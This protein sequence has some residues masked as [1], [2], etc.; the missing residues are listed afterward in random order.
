MYDGE[1]AATFSNN[2]HGTDRV[3]AHEIAERIHEGHGAHGGAHAEPMHDALR[4]FTGIYLGFVAMLLALA[5][6]GGSHATKEML[7]ANIHASD[8][9]AY[10]QAKYLRQIDYQIAADQLEILSASA[11]GTPP[12]AAAMIK[13]YRTTA[14]RYESEPATGNGKKELVAKAKA[15]E[16]RRD[17]AAAQDPNFDYAEALF[18]IAIVLGSVSIVAASRALLGLSSALAACGVVLLANGYLLLVPLPFG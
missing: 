11:S 10:Y 5:A 14:A 2:R 12:A 9:Y 6:L 1:A 3:E 15:W 16:E 8:T 7:N 13:R 18:Q 4:R 17:R